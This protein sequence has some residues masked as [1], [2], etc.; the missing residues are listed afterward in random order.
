MRAPTHWTT[1]VHSW[2]RRYSATRLLRSHAAPRRRGVAVA[3][4][5][6]IATDPSA[7]QKETNNHSKRAV[8]A[9]MR[10]ATLVPLLGVPSCPRCTL[11]LGSS[12]CTS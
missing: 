7:Q 10:D 8:G 5:Q 6:G 12:T 11:R 3:H 1:T 4:T 2:M 9:P